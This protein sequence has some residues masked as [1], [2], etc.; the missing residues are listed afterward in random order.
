MSK[1]PLSNY[2]E[3]NANAKSLHRRLTPISEHG[4][5]A[6]PVST[7]NHL[8]SK[9]AASL[10]DRLANNPQTSS[11]QLL[12]LAEEQQE[13]PIHGKFLQRWRENA[14]NSLGVERRALGK[15]DWTMADWQQLERDLG[16]FDLDVVRGP[17]DELP[18][19]L[20]VAASSYAPAEAAVV[21][22]N[23]QLFQQ[24]LSML[25][26]KACVHQTVGGWYPQ[27][28]PRW[29]GLPHFRRAY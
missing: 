13:T 8:T 25:S 6:A 17:E 19:S 15:F 9:A 29:V 5:F 18:N 2:V 26:N 21:L 23:P 1:M 12:K 4:D 22:F 10:K 28:F 16:C 3:Y 24:V 14:L 11:L 7:W 20:L 27:A